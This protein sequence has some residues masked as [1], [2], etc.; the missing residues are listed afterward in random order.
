MIRPIVRIEV[1]KKRISSVN[2]DRV[3]YN[4]TPDYVYPRDAAFLNLNA[5]R[6]IEK[7]KDKISFNLQNHRELLDD[8][9]FEYTL[10]HETPQLESKDLIKV[11][12]WNDGDL[13]D[14][15]EN[16]TESQKTN[17]HIMTAYVKS[18]DYNS[19]ET[20]GIFSITC[21]NRT[22]VLLNSFMFAPY[23]EGERVPVMIVDSV[24]KIKN[25]NQNDLV[26]AFMD[27]NPNGTP[28][29]KGAYDANG[30]RVYYELDEDGNKVYNING[31]GTPEVGYVR[32]YKKDAYKTD[33][34]GE[35]KDDY[36]SSVPSSLQFEK[37]TFVET[38]KPF[39]DHLED[40]STDKYTGDTTAGVYVSYVDEHNY[41]HWE[42]KLF[43]V[44][45]TINEYEHTS[46]SLSKDVDE[47][48]NAVIVNAGTDP[49]HNGVLALSFNASSMGLNG[50]RWMYKGKTDIID[51]IYRREKN[52]GDRT[53]DHGNLIS[54]TDNAGNRI[55]ENGYPE[56][57]PWIIQTSESDL[58]GKW[59]YVAGTTTVNSNDEYKNYIR[60]VGKRQGERKGDDII[61]YS[62]DP[63]I[64]CKW[65][66]ENGN[67]DFQP[68]QMITI[69][70]PSLNLKKTL[71][72]MSITDTFANDWK[73]TL[74]LEEDI[75][76]NLATGA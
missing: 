35:L 74:E 69:N 56:S 32:A 12:A 1:Y 51:E 72:I 52:S 63:R 28:G 25:Y 8:G 41:L 6:G 53:D 10:V 50:A 3:Y 7:R 36:T 20:E 44:K 55:A 71:R 40:L 68:N 47:V 19:T 23:N 67:T 14:V 21:F 66:L 54:G 29:E 38:Y 18:Y 22:E 37:I 16:L 58:Y 49:N 26:I 59:S 60:R 4:S 5:T 46:I 17:F 76:Y 30:N 33:G 11:Y 48:I 70:I 39:I 57:Y 62:G 43:D 73:T 61:K 27:Y 24:N 75:D 34:S 31:I 65:E 13:P 42:P 15:W 9:S 45:A 64:K 2:Q